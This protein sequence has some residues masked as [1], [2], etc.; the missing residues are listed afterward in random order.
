MTLKDM[1]ENKD[2]VEVWGSQGV[3]FLKVGSDISDS[4]HLGPD[5]TR[6]QY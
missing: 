5:M 2:K 1:L 4:L 3:Y 6:Q